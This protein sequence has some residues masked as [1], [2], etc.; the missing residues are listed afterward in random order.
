MFGRNHYICVGSDY[1]AILWTYSASSD[2]YKLYTYCTDI[3]VD[4]YTDIAELFYTS[5]V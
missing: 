4:N 2:M 1:L 5:M 3:Y